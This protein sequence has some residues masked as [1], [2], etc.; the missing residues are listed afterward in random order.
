EQRPLAQQEAATFTARLARAVQAFHDQGACHGRLSAGWVLVR[1]DLE[2]LLCPC[3]TPSQ[4]AAD[5]A[6]DVRAPGRPLGA[7]I[8]QVPREKPNP[9]LARVCD[10]AEAGH[11]ARPADLA[12]D[13][14]RAVKVTRLRQRE[15]WA[16]A[17]AVVLMVLPLVAPAVQAIAQLLNDRWG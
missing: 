12:D 8:G 6:A 3:G 14:D 17:L 11:Y 4:S 1:G 5:R 15:G 2:P 9:V 16:Y 13:L 10:A 7:W